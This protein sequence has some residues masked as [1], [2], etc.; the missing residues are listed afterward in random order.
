M[1]TEYA[2]VITTTSSKPAAAKIAEALLAQR[3]AACIQVMPI[4]SYYHW[5][6]RM[7]VEEEQQLVIKCKQADFADIQQCII[8]NHS[9]EIPE[10]I[11]LPIIA[12]APAYLQWI[13]EVTR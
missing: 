7:Q 6:G 1:S 5:Q 2:I 4:Q 12:G 10:I 13:G 8:A 3:L 11:Q 9:Y